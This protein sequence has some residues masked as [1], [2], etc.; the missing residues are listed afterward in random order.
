MLEMQ[1]QDLSNFHWLKVLQWKM[2]L[3][4]TNEEL[5]R[6]W[7]H[8]LSSPF[9]QT[10]WVTLVNTLQEIQMFQTSI[11]QMN[12]LQVI[13]HSSRYHPYDKMYT[14]AWM[15]ITN[16]QVCDNWSNGQILSS[17]PSQQGSRYDETRRDECK[18]VERALEGQRPK[19]VG[20]GAGLTVRRQR[21][22]VGR[23]VGGG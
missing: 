21:A 22:G 9:P 8:K 6:I 3:Y 16:K 12:L 14:Y 5:S 15:T 1:L 19:M 17:V 11:K 20:G 10:T 4:D 18:K 23:A 7:C 13:N 2:L